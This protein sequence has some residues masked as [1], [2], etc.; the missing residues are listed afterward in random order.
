VSKKRALRALGL[1]YSTLSERLLNLQR[2]LSD[3]AEDLE[4][5]LRQSTKEFVLPGGDDVRGRSCENGTF[6][7]RGCLSVCQEATAAVVAAVVREKEM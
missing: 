7:L 6:A 1:T 4:A 5:T 2:E 3:V